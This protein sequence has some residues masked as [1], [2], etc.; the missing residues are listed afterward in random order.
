M[1]RCFYNRKNHCTETLTK[2]HVVSNSVLKALDLSSNGVIKADVMNN[3]PIIDYDAVVKDVCSKCNNESLSAYDK[4]GKGLVEFLVDN[5][6]KKLSTIP[7]GKLEFGWLL[8][9]HLNFFRVVKDKLTGKPFKVSQKIKNKLID[10]KSFD[11]SQCFFLVRQID[12]SES[13]WDD[14]SEKVLPMVHYNSKRLLVG[15]LIYSHFQ[16]RQLQ[17]VL[18]FPLDGNYKN[19]E[20]RFE[21]FIEQWNSDPVTQLNFDMEGYELIDIELLGKRNFLPLT[22]AM[23]A[24]K[25]DKRIGKAFNADDATHLTQ[26]MKKKLKV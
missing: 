8:K 21:K 23:S 13:Y 15:D 26:L 1:K 6:H 22:Y 11:N 25:L 10:G 17:T 5:S 18:F 20:R 2:E 3:T 14:D 16:I 19:F 12:C 7:F 9:T 4:S 24:E